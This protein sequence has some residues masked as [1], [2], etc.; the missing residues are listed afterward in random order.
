MKKQ[1]KKKEKRVKEMGRWGEGERERKRGRKEGRKQLTKP[2]LSD[3]FKDNPGGGK[4]S[5][6]NGCISKWGTQILSQPH[7]N[8]N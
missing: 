1:T 4:N 6:Q 2:S 5:N 8:Y 3:D 7:Q